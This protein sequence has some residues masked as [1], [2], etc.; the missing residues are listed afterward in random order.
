MIASG[1]GMKNADK[2]FPSL[3]QLGKSKKDGGLRSS[4]FFSHI[5]NAVG[6]DK[7]DFD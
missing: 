2:A 5:I 7:L 6:G 1:M 4:A 3:S